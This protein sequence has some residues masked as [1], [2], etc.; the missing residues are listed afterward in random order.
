[1]AHKLMGMV[2]ALGPAFADFAPGFNPFDRL[3]G[4]AGAVAIRLVIYQKSK[5]AQKYRRDEEYGSA[6]WATPKEISETYTWVLFKMQD[7]RQGKELP[8]V[9]GLILGSTGKKDKVTALIDS[10]DIHCLMIGASGFGKTAFFLYPNLEYACAS[11]MSFLTLDTKGDFARNYG[12]IAAEC[13][14]YQVAVIDLRNPMRSNSNNFL[15]LVN[16]Y[17]DISVKSPQNV[18]AKAKMEKY[19]RI[20]AKTIISPDGDSSNRGQNAFFMTPPKEI[21]GKK[22][23]R[24]HIVS[25]FKLVQDLLEPASG[26]NKGKSQFQV[27]MSKLPSEHKA[28]WFVDAAVVMKTG[29]NPMRTRLRLFLDWGITFGEPYRMQEHGQRK[30]YYADRRELETAILKKYPPPNM[31]HVPRAA[32]AQSRSQQTFCETD[33]DGSSL[34]T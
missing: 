15:T 6:R 10:D 7:W 4:I 34:R 17:M 12:A 21:D 14:G 22:Q 2:A 26:A 19:A 1:M 20:L 31:G 27:L 3:A 33:K 32:A 23:E 18:A 8:K 9:Q 16:Q 5:K 24:R 28:R 25:V 29:T 11:G 13:Y 30:V